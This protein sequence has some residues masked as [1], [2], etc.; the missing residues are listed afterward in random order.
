MSL[1]FDK[2]S[3]ALL[4][5]FCLINQSIEFVKGKTISTISVTKSMFASG[6][7]NVEIPH[8][9]AIYDLAKM[10]NFISMFGDD[11]QIDI[12][13]NKL[14]VG[15]KTGSERFTCHFAN[16]ELIITPPRDKKIELPS[17]DVEFS[18]T[19]E[20]LQRLM[21]AVNIVGV[22][23]LVINCDINNIS[24]TG[25]NTRDSSSDNYSF[26]ITD[27]SVKCK[28]KLECSIKVEDLRVLSD[29]YIV[30]V[31]DQGMAK[32]SGSNDLQYYIGVQV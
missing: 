27:S 11:H 26:D 13:P 16:R 5:N 1:Q 29:N 12:K 6:Q 32:F 18:L 7:L 31:C 19:K 10:L 17:I 4:E 23:D 25:T 14:I 30:Q 8:D 3:L 22:T 21:K 2:N 20:Q 24:V 28:R 9:F 15:S